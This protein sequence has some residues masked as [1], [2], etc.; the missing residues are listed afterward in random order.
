[1]CGTNN[2]EQKREKIWSKQMA[3]S[4]STCDWQQTP[5]RVANVVQT[6]S[7]CLMHGHGCPRSF[8]FINERTR[9]PSIYHFCLRNK[10]KCNLIILINHLDGTLFRS[11]RQTSNQSKLIA[12]MSN[13]ICFRRSSEWQFVSICDVAHVT[14]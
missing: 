8:I 4:M 2:N 9:T 11:K 12:N 14:N 1:M 10:E 13:S 6:V 3:F 5:T 7:Q